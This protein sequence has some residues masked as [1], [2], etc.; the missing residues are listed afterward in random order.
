MA[1]VISL[2]MISTSLLEEAAKYIDAEKEVN[3]AEE[4][5]AG[6]KDI[7]AESISDEADYRSKIRDLTV[8]SGRLISA[9]KD[10][11]TESV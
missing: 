5:I 3:T 4:A 7:I 10:P 1:N 8:K 11:E 9:A 2:Q 6:A